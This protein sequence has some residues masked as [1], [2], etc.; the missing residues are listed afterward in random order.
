[1]VEEERL[2][3]FCSLTACVAVTDMTY[4]HP[5]REFCHLRL[6]EHLRNKAITLYSM[7]QTLMVNGN[8]A[9]SLLSSVLES[10]QAVICKACSIFNTIDS[11]YTTLM[12]QLV[13]P[14][15]IVTL[16]HFSSFYYSPLK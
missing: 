8:Y 1:M 2:K 6:I 12:M 15:N 7:K 5:A 13:I 10:M 4:G 16:T 9:A 14:I 3:V 11:K